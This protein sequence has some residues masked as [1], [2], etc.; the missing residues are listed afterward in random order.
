MTLD[1]GRLALSA[2]LR[3][4]GSRALTPLRQDFEGESPI[5][6]PGGV[7]DTPSDLGGTLFLLGV[8]LMTC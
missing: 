8:M 7:A 4:P 5:A 3:S 6:S 1:G 2:M